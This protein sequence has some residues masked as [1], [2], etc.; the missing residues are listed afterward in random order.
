EASRFVSRLEEPGHAYQCDSACYDC[1]K[2]YYNM[3]YHPLLDWRLGRDMV[4]LLRGRGLGLEAWG[5]IERQRAEVFASEFDGSLDDFS[6]VPGVE[7]GKALVL[8]C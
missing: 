5:P 4:G 7:L 6:G 8:V 1:L 2:D 3:A